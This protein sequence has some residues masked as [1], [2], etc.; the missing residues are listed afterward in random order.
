VPRLRPGEPKIDDNK[1]ALLLNTALAAI[2]RRP[3][4]IS[5]R[6]GRNY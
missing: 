3:D 6:A 5:L 1:A 2:D 4:G